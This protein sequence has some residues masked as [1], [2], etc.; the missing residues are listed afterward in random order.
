MAQVQNQFNFDAFNELKKTAPA[1]LKVFLAQQ[2]M[3]E[4]L[5]T[6]QRYR[7]PL[8]HE[9][10]NLCD[11]IADFRE[12]WK[13]QAA[14]RDRND[15]SIATAHID[16]LESMKNFSNSADGG[17]IDTA[18]AGL[19]QIAANL[20]SRLE[21]LEKSRDEDKEDAIALVQDTLSNMELMT[22]NSAAK[23][24]SA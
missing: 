23:A 10:S 6:A 3:D 13:R 12:S 1:G 15:S 19:A 7:N 11:E 18:Q 4:V 20:L 24:P 2:L 17:K 8:R 22:G 21:A 5:F 9:L 16:N 14:A